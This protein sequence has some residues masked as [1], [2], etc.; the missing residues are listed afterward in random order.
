MRNCI[1]LVVCDIPCTVSSEDSFVPATEWGWLIGRDEFTSW[2]LEDRDDLAVLNK[3][4]GVV[5]HP[6]KHGPWSSLIGAAR[7]YFGIPVAYMP[8]RL[9]RE[10]S[11]VWMVAKTRERGVELQRAVQER[12][13]R[14]SY[15][16]ILD[17]NLLEAITV[18]QPIGAAE[19]S[20]VRLKRA[21]RPDGQPAVTYFEPL[22]VRGGY[23]LVRVRTETG[24][25][26]QIRV[27]AAWLGCPLVGD[28]VYGP[29][30]SLFIEFIER[31]YTGRVAAVLPL[32]RQ[33]LHCESVTVP[34]EAWTARLAS[35]LA[36]FWDGLV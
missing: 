23:T 28:K 4:P 10:T 20:L 21:V 12:Q 2:I 25:L 33:A 27:H 17:G 24:R 13:V 5:C 1:P 31:G 8:F 16:A 26:H 3:P 22:E 32:P 35:D 9:D 7:E 14:K 15:L 36:A 30:E 18:D 34:G 29:D 11:G 6:S 19:G